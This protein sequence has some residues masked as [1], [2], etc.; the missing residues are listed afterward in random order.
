MV[1]RR[2]GCTPYIEIYENQKRVFTSWTDYE[3]LRCAPVSTELVHH[4]RRLILGVVE[5]VGHMSRA[6]AQGARG[7][8]RPRAVRGGARALRRHHHL[9]LPRAPRQQRAR[10]ARLWRRTEGALALFFN[11]YLLPASCLYLLLGVARALTLPSASRSRI[12][13]RTCSY[14]TGLSLPL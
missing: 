7:G 12:R 11:S 6:R 4:R 14:S 5:Q 9:L 3:K 1:V 2:N 10:R 13:A 8:A